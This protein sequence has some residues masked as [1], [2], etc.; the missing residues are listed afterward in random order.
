MICSIR[1]ASLWFAQQIGRIIQIYE[2]I[3]VRFAQIRWIFICLIILFV[4]FAERI[5]DQFVQFAIDLDSNR[6]I[7]SILFSRFALIGSI[8]AASFSDSPIVTCYR[9]FGNITAV[10]RFPDS[11]H[12]AKFNN[13]MSKNPDIECPV[14]E[15]CPDMKAVWISS[16]QIY[17]I[18]STTCFNIQTF[19]NPDIE[20]SDY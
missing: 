14:I 18:I 17:M 5:N 20:A 16:V 13:R 1:S 11:G 2:S 8:C 12:Q 3:L 15:A 19:S 4:R 7:R 9:R 10:L 6:W